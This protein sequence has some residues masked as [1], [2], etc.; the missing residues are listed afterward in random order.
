MSVYR[1]ILVACAIAC[2]TVFTSAA[3]AQCGGCG[4]VAVVPVQPVL[5]QPVVEVQ[6]I[7]VEPAVVPVAPAPIGVSC[8]DTNGFCGGGCGGGCGCGGGGGGCGGCGGGGCG[9]FAG[10]GGFGG[11]GGFGGG[12]CGGGGCGGCGG[13]SSTFGYHPVA[14]APLYVVNQGPEYSGPGLMVPFGTYSP[15]TNVAAPGAYPYVAGR[16]YGY[17]PRYPRP[18]YGSRY[19]YTGRYWGN[20][21]RYYPN[22]WR[23]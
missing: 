4:A 22:R 13:C 7:V 21:S 18:H 10:V 16:G 6:P 9:G 15:A 23:G 5:V 11:F 2:V 20:P 14:P 3:F 8:W 19:T 1:T 17:G 12:G